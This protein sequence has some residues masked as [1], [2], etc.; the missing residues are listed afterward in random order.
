M[1]GFRLGFEVGGKGFKSWAQVGNAVGD[2]GKHATREDFRHGKGRGTIFLCNQ[3]EGSNT[4][5]QSKDHSI[6]PH[7]LLVGFVRAYAQGKLLFG[8]DECFEFN[9]FFQSNGALD[10]L[11]GGVPLGKLCCI[12]E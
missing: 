8:R 5:E 10:L 11:D 4:L 12:G 2:H 3:S 7:H 6:F 1:Q 9:I